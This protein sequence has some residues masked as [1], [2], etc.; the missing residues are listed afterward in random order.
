[1]LSQLDPVRIL[2]WLAVSAIALVCFAIVVGELWRVIERWRDKRRHELIL[3][4]HKEAADY[5]VVKQIV[6]EWKFREAVRE[7]INEHRN[8]G[9]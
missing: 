3:L 9:R 5:S 7:V 2:G 1:M 6:A 8:G 4:I